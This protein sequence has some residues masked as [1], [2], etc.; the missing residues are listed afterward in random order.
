MMREVRNI[1]LGVKLILPFACAWAKR[2]ES[3]ILKTGA[4]LS[5]EQSK[6]AARLGIQHPERIRLRAVAEVPPLNWLL[7]LLG[8]KLGVVSGQTIGMTLRYGIFIRE[9]HWGDRRLLAHELA[10]VAQYERLGGFRGFLKPYL[11]EC[12]NPG[13]PLGDLELEA[14]KAESLAST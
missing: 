2:Q 13:Y 9:E 4:P 12:I 14:K 3:T 8:Q 1:S 11:E 5:L 6:L 7:R 10:H